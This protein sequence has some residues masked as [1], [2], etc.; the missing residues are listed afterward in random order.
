[1]TAKQIRLT[2][3]RATER[4]PG[5]GGYFPDRSFKIGVVEST[6]GPALGK[7]F[8]IAYHGTV[9]D[10]GGSEDDA[11]TEAVETLG[12]KYGA[13]VQN[14]SFVAFAGDLA[15]CATIVTAYKP[16]GTLLAFCVTHPDYQRR[17]LAKFLLRQSLDVLQQSGITHLHLVVTEANTGAVKLYESLGFEEKSRNTAVV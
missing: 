4:L 5:S 9:D 16:L 11:I 7:L 14:S 15:V 8:Y 2:M 3:V 6:D 13:L 1:M 12:G 10:E 17:G